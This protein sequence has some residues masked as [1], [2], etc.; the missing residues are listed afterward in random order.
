MMMIPAECY[1]RRDRWQAPFSEEPALQIISAR[2]SRVSKIRPAKDQLEFSFGETQAVEVIPED[3]E[4]WVPVP[5]WPAYQV[6]DVGGVRSCWKRV[7]SPGRRG[8]RM[9]L[10]DQWQKFKCS[11]NGAG[12]PRVLLSGGDGRRKEFPVAHLVLLAFV[13]PCPPGMECVYDPDPSYLNCRL[14]NLDW[15]TRPRVTEQSKVCEWCGREFKRGKRCPEEWEAA[16]GCSISCSQKVRRGI[17]S[18][19]PD[20]LTLR[21]LYEEEQLS[22]GAIGKMF[23]VSGHPVSCWLKEAGIA[24]RSSGVGLASRGVEPPDHDT[25]YRLIYEEFKT[26]QQVADI[27]GVDLT[28][29]PYWLKKHDIPRPKFWNSRNK[30]VEPVLPDADTI[31]SLYAEGKSLRQ[32]GELHG[33]DEGKV[34]ELC[35]RFGIEKRPGGFNQQGGERYRCQDGRMVRSSYEKRVADWLYNHGI[36]YIYEPTLPFGKN[37]LGDFL[38]NGWYIEVW[39]VAGNDQYDERKERKI[40]GYRS[41]QVPLIELS[42]WHFSAARASTLEKRLQRC[43]TS[44][45]DR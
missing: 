23:G 1:L 32:I 2:R 6:S 19:R 35:D 34:S 43:L 31:R 11:L 42:F 33:I 17:E 14:T 26:Y 36:A 44:P 20:P 12:Q 18:R 13:G 22:A 25:L 3:I 39:G 21:R 30:G 5:D 15:G 7:R 24:R 8:S 29:V 16:R 10:S 45:P 28:S 4:R 40:A 38:A 9:I 27:Y 41:A 37:Y